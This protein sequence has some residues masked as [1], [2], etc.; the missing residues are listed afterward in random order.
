MECGSECALVC[1]YLYLSL[2][3]IYIVAD[4]LSRT[5][6]DNNTEVDV[7]NTYKIFIIKEAGEVNMK[8]LISNLATE[9]EREDVY[10]RQQYEKW[11]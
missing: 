9:E 11:G 6:F 2:I 4:V 5:D 3:H 10:K 1:R 7:A 8:K